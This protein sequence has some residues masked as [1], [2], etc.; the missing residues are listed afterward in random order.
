MIVRK[1]RTASSKNKMKRGL[2]L[3][4]AILVINYSFLLG[5]LQDEMKSTQSLVSQ[6]TVRKNECKEKEMIIAERE[7]ELERGFRKDLGD[8]GHYLAFFMKN[9]K[10]KP[11]IHGHNLDRAE[12]YEMGIHALK[13]PNLRAFGRENGDAARAV[14]SAFIELEDPTSMPTG[15]PRTYWDKFCK[16]RRKRL[17][18]D[19][20]IKFVELEMDNIGKGLQECSEREDTTAKS[21][22]SVL[23]ILSHR[24]EMRNYLLYNTE[25]QYVTGKGNVEINY[26][27]LENHETAVMTLADSVDRLNS[28]VAVR[29]KREIE[30]IFELVTCQINLIVILEFY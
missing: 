25:F 9:Y 26:W 27:K 19:F 28:R 6:L 21:M 20:E 24:T 17:I 12:V 10:R 3:N 8:V 14:V 11:K 30:L 7:S 22:A 16:L 1:R 13:S 5:K 2:N 15:C 23:A 29:Q 4:N 18:C